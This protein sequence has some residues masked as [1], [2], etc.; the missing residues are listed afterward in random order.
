MTSNFLLINCEKT[1]VLIIGPKT[2]TCSVTILASV[3]SV[4]SVFMWMSVQGLVVA[5]K[6]RLAEPAVAST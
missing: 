5:G 1:E 3:F 6:M 2:P 4:W